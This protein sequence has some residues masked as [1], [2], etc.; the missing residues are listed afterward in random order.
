MHPF[1]QNLK[2]IFE[3]MQQLIKH[4]QQMQKENE[5]LRSEVEASNQRYKDLMEQASK[6]EQ[7]AEILKMSR[8]T[9]NETEKKALEK[10]LN[11]YVKE[12][13]RCIALL[14]E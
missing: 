9:M 4:H 13:D 11:K 8:G 14:H 3:K 1:E 6:W 5:K 7:Q 12:I 10:R 2:N